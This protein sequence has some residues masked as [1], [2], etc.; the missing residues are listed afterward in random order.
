[1]D[2]AITHECLDKLVI[3]KKLKSF[4]LILFRANFLIYLIVDYKFFI[5]L[6]VYSFLCRFI[7]TSMIFYTLV[8][9]GEVHELD[10]S[11]IIV[12]RSDLDLE[13]LEWLEPLRC[14]SV[15]HADLS[16]SFSRSVEPIVSVS[17]SAELM[18][19]VLLFLSA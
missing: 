15:F 2:I 8:R 12:I 4:S 14:V 19:S 10:G 18:V 5:F 6:K 16:W 7:T 3:R 11:D 13:K 1:M 17:H 9:S